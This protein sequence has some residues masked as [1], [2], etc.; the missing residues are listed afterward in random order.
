MI[1]HI[2]PRSSRWVPRPVW[3]PV[4]ADIVLKRGVM[5]RGRVTGG[6]DG[7]PVRARVQYFVESS[8]PHMNDAS[9]LAGAFHAVPTR[10]DGS[11]AVPALLGGGLLAV[12]AGD[13]FLMADRWSDLNFGDATK[14]W[15]PH[16]P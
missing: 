11:F 7:Q 2:S 9:G 10:P 12:R 4:T 5:I 16:N 15:W 8:N 3:K 6:P 14:D 1:S 13:G